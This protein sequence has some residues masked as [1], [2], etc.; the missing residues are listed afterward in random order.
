MVWQNGEM[1]S[2]WIHIPKL[3]VQVWFLLFLNSELLDLNLVLYI[4][5]K[6][7]IKLGL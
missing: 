5:N 1:V 7:K 2:R 3:S 4:T 6:N